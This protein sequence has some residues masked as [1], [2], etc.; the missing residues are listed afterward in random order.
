[1]Q[2]HHNPTTRIL[3]FYTQKAT[4]ARG[5][6]QKNTNYSFICEQKSGASTH[7]SRKQLSKPC[8]TVCFMDNYVAIT[9]YNMHLSTR[10]QQDFQDIVK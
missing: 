9:K 8:I 6:L 7:P 1:M 10:H 5:G 2:I 3:R 4:C